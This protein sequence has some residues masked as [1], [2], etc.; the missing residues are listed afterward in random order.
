LTFSNPGGSSA[1]VEL[2]LTPADGLGGGSS[3]TVSQDLGPGTQLV[4]PDALAFFTQQGAARTALNAAASGGG[5]V[6]AS[7][8]NLPAKAIVYGGARTTALSGLGRAGLSYAAPAAE[9]LF[10]RPVAIYGLRE[11]AT[12]R[13]NL[14]LENAGTSGPIDL[15]VT[16]VSGAGDTRFVL[17]DTVSLRAGQWSQIGSILKAAGYSSGW[18]LVER[19]S[20][21]DPFY[22]YGVSNDNL[23]NDGAFLAAVSATRTPSVQVVPA[24][25]ETGAFGSELVLV[26]PGPAAATVTL[27]FI[28]SLASPLGNSTGFVTLTLRPGEQRFIPDVVATLR[29]QGASVGPKGPAYAGPLFVRFTSGGT[30]AD[31]F[32]ASRTS[33]P[34]AGGG[35]YGVSYPGVT[36]AESAS[37]EA[38]VFGLQ[39]NAANRSNFAMLNAA[40]NLGPVSL[41][42]DVFDGSTGTKAGGASVQLY[43]GQ[44]MQVNAILKT[45][46]LANGYV[47]VTRT[48]GTA[49]WVAYGILNDGAVPGAGTGDGSFIGMTPA[50]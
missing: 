36:L 15:R 25:V 29:A 7:F 20:G 43:P 28:E 33:T 47:R 45:Y 26:N 40:S 17:P 4:I 34:A 10:D 2:T 42:Y 12:E 24:I 27:N 31:G 39:Q 13:T 18:A 5:S 46:G 37:G 16:L 38:W 22:A 9:E 48:A 49:P 44:W 19:V 6:R 11:T 32:A 3:S 1:H 23:T 35:G 21:T 50:P 41:R 30:A 8:T 14:A